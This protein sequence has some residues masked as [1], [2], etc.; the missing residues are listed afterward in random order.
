MN[1]RH[2]SSRLLF[3]AL[4]AAA[5]ALAG[6]T[7]P[8]TP[9]PAATASANGSAAGAS[10]GTSATASA[11]T[12]SGLDLDEAAGA[13]LLVTADGG[14]VAVRSGDWT[15]LVAVPRGA[16][17]DGARWRVV[18]LRAAPDGI[19]DA[20]GPG[21]YVDEAGQ[22]PTG[23]CVIAFTTTGAADPDAAIYR[24]AEDGASAE[25]VATDRRQTDA[26]T[27]LMAEV[28]GFSSYGV[29]TATKAARAKAKQQRKKQQQGHYVISV[30]DKVTFTVQD[31]KFR[32]SLDMN[33]AGGGATHGGSYKGVAT[34]VFTGKYTKNLGGVIQGLGNIK[35]S[36][37]GSTTAL[38]F[39]DL[40]PLGPL[41]PLDDQD[42]PYL[43]E[44]DDVGGY[45]SFVIK[46]SGSLN[47]LAKAPAGTYRAPG[48]PVKDGVKM[49]FRISVSGENVTV[50][51]ANLGEFSG[52]L[53]KF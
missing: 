38:L 14:R 36:G 45:G 42:L 51:I 47:M 40:G 17:A 13:D 27:I 12:P 21:V 26:G 4:L 15:A 48:I 29:G 24:L 33:L 19:P 50:E 22:P 49:P 43:M 16:A 30:H 11:S 41:L 37:K 20:L 9:G 52:H 2:L 23:D 6:C 34:L 5:V 25:L 39:G 10:P 35:W 8:A 31:W 1:T 44:M 18:P 46:G 28:S 32:A 53:T 3:A 7:P